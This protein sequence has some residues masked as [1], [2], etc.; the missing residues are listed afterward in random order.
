ML[1]HWQMIDYIIIPLFYNKT[2]VALLKMPLYNSKDQ[3]QHE[4]PKQEFVFIPLNKLC[5]IISSNI[6]SYVTL[7][8]HRC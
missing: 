7:C 2:K 3:D 8:K 1:V 4:K 6:L 5:L